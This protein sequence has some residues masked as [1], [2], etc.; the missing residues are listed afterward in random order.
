MLSESSLLLGAC[1]KN[2]TNVDTHISPNHSLTGK[3][4]R[5]AAIARQS[6][7]AQPVG[8]ALGAKPKSATPIAAP[9]A[10]FGKQTVALSFHSE[11]VR[12]NHRGHREHK[13]E[14]QEDS[15]RLSES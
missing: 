7:P 14:M 8:G 13:E 1:K 10:S 15:L 12:E 5:V 9:P 3:A 4:S 11:L 6:G 2:E